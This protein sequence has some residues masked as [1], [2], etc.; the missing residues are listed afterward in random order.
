MRPSLR[1]A[2]IYFIIGATWILLSDV[3]VD[4]FFDDKHVI[5]EL[6]TYKGWTFV[7][8][9]AL[10]IFAL[11]R[12]YEKH[13]NNKIAELRNANQDLK[14]FFYK[15]SHDLRGPVKSILGLTALMQMNRHDKDMP[16]MVTHIEQSARKADH[17]IYD[18]DQLTNIIEGPLQTAPVNFPALLKKIF[19][20]LQAQN[21]DF[22]NKVN[23]VSQLNIKECQSHLYLLELIMEK[24]LENAIVFTAP[25]RDS[26]EVAVL[27]NRTREGLSIKVKDNGIGIH[28]SRMHRIF[29]MF[30]KG[31]EASKGSG[32]GLHIVR[33]AVERLDGKVLVDST[34]RIGSTFTALIPLTDNS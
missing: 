17:L 5:R 8:L 18:L 21:P 12:Q 6:Q 25:Y 13:L 22:A 26:P 14:L 24:L 3:A 30:Y 19:A 23:M 15:A 16:L 20:R 1:I 7:V 27:I 28:E 2:T 10:L 33:L 31:T 32:L 4:T 11:S 29:D 9:S 34:E